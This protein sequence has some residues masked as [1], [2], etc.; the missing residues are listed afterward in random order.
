[1]HLTCCVLLG[2][3]ATWGVSFT[4]CTNLDIVTVS[5][6][7][8]ID[9]ITCSTYNFV[10]QRVPPGNII[11]NAVWKACCVM[12]PCKW[13]SSI[14]CKMTLYH[15]AKWSTWKSY[16]TIEQH[17]Q[18]CKH[19]LYIDCMQPQELPCDQ[20]NECILAYSEIALWGYC[21]DIGGVDVLHQELNI[22]RHEHSHLLLV[23]TAHRSCFL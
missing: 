3:C 19:P 11:F 10:S 20:D 1:M 5:W 23:R 4:H 12:G 15:R 2:R 16:Y 14:I 17:T 21:S 7:Q 22:C 6:L 18:A 13:E 8:T 9:G